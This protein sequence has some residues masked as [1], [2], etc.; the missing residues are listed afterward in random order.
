MF[1]ANHASGHQK[2]LL[3]SSTLLLWLR[4]HTEQKSPQNPSSS[5]IVRVSHAYIEGPKFELEIQLE[6]EIEIQLEL[7]TEL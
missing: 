6:I 3:P 5:I 1:I 7:E 2:S 4:H